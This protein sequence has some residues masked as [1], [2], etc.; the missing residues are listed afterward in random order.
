MLFTTAA[1]AYGAALAGV[2]LTGA[3]SDGAEGLKRIRELGGR[4]FV[5]DPSEAEVDTMPI[6]ALARAGADLCA[7]LAAIAAALD[8]FGRPA[9]RTE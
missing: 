5:Q 1:E 9:G 4:A 8:G 3:S 2:V 7:P 6:A